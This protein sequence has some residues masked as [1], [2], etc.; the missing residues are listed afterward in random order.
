MNIIN[1]NVHYFEPSEINELQRGIQTFL[2]S[3][4]PEK[5]KDNS[6]WHRFEPDLSYVFEMLQAIKLNPDYSMEIYYRKDP[7]GSYTYLFAVPK[8]T[9]C[10]PFFEETCTFKEIL[11]EGGVDLL[12]VIEGD[13]SP[14][15]YAETS[16]LYRELSK[17]CNGW[18]GLYSCMGSIISCEQ[19]YLKATN[20]DTIQ[21]HGKWVNFFLPTD[22]RPLVLIHD[23]SAYFQFY[24]SLHSG[25]DTIVRNVDYYCRSRNDEKFGQR[26][27]D[28]LFKS[29][30]TTVALGEQGP[31]W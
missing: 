18:H 2:K 20:S 17:S 8:G 14:W 5:L 29:E 25:V 6:G 13:H 3:K 31:M 28:Y 7:L 12:S 16:I 11:P 27:G 30:C 24:S 9:V 10:E 1:K 23:G 4:K 21:N 26:S 15:S 22:W 19:D